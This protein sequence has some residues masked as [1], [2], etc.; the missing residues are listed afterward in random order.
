MCVD[1]RADLGHVVAQQER[2]DEST[3]IAEPH[4]ARIRREESQ[5]GKPDLRAVQDRVVEYKAWSEPPESQPGHGKPHPPPRPPTSARNMRHAR[6]AT[7]SEPPPDRLQARH[8]ETGP[9]LRQEEH[10]DQRRRECAPD[11]GMPPPPPA[12]RQQR[13]DQRRRVVGVMETEGPS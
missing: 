7:F 5:P 9:R 3:R 2:R 11:P 12:Q 4:A 8:E 10:R 1:E 13:T 6:R